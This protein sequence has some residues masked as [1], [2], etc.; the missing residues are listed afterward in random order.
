METRE[1]SGRRTN[2]V[3]HSHTHTES[4]HSPLRANSP[5]RSDDADPPFSTPEASPGKSPCKAIVALDKFSRAKTPLEQRKAVPEHRKHAV[6]RMEPPNLVANAA[7]DVTRR[8]GAETEE[9]SPVV[10]YNRS[11]REDMS[12]VPKVEDGG[13]RR[14]GGGELEDGDGG[15]NRPA[16]A[17]TSILKRSRR[18]VMLRRG[19]LGFRICEVVFCLISFSVMAA[20]K[21]QGWSGDS[22]DRYKEYRFVSINQQLNHFKNI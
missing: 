6:S 10:E 7:T 5:L 18:E 2:S 3:S 21:T 19:A 1:N 16:R 11:V 14:G 8:N 12:V 17:L 15:E 9:K 13:G 20:D 4:F 22:F